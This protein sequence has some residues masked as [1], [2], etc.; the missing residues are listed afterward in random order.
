[1]SSKIRQINQKKILK[2]NHSSNTI[3]SSTKK[4]IEN[5]F[6]YH[7]IHQAS[8]SFQISLDENNKL[9]IKTKNQSKS[10]NKIPNNESS[11]L[12]NIQLIDSDNVKLR[13]VLTE[14][15]KEL[16]E[17]DLVLNQSQKLLKKINFEYTQILN[18]YQAI[19]QEKNILKK[20]NERLKHLC[21]ILN[22]NLISKEKKEKQNEQIKFELNKTK[23]LLNNFKDHYINISGDFTKI[24]K[25]MIYKDL[26]INDLKKE[27]NKIINMVHD[28]EMIIKQYSKKLSELKELIEQ[29]DEQIKLMVNFSKELNSENKLNIKEITKQAVK[30]INTFYNTRNNKSKDINSNLIEIK[31]DSILNLNNDENNGI[32][33][34]ILSKKNCCFL[35]YKAIKSDLYIPENGINFI[36]KEFLE[37]NNIKT[38]LIKTELYS[39]ILR[40]FNLFHFI[41]NR[42]HKFEE[43]LINI[44]I[45]KINYGKSFKLFK[46]IYNVIY[47]NLIKTKKENSNLKSKLNELILYIKKLKNDFSTKNKKIKQKFETLINQYLSKFNKEEIISNLYSNNNNENIDKNNKKEISELNK[48]IDKVKNINKNL[49]EEISNKD[50]IINKLRNDNNKLINKLNLYRTNPN[51]ENNFK[52]YNSF[53]TKENSTSPKNLFL[54]SKNGEDSYKN[55]NNGGG[56]LKLNTKKVLNLYSIFDN[57][58]NK[59]NSSKYSN[60]KKKENKN[61]K[62]IRKNKSD[63]NIF[64]SENNHSLKIYNKNSFIN[65]KIQ[66][67]ENIFFKSNNSLTL[68]NN[69]CLNNSNFIN[70]ILSII[71]DFTS[72]ISEE[73]FKEIVHTFF[74][75]NQIIFMLNDKISDIKNNLSLIIEK[76]KSNNK[77]KKIKPGQFMDMLHEVE[78][79]L[80]YLF[81]QL[82]KYS[83][84][85]KNILPFLKCIFALVSIISYNNPLNVNEISK[86][87]NLKDGIPFSFEI[88]NLMNTSTSNYNNK[89]NS[90]QYIKDRVLSNYINNQKSIEIGNKYF[91]NLFY[92]NTK[93]FSS[94]ELIKYRS[95]YEGLELDQILPVFKEIC[96]NFKK[97]ILNS[98]FSYESEISDIE[99]NIDLNPNKENII[100]K[101]NNTYHIVNEKIFGLKK[102]EFNFKLFFEVLKN[103]LVAF[104]IVVKYIEINM[105][106]IQYKK[107]LKRIINNLY[108][109]FEDSACLNM[110]CLDDNTIFCRKILL[111]LLLN[112]KEY[113]SNFI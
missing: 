102:F 9:N 10:S 89:F 16:K 24:E 8:K 13:E 55:N 94:S 88:D 108:E 104:E 81:N 66:Y 43:S 82:N 40:E 19:E 105:T 7:T 6:K 103:Y 110:H 83:I 84:D 93:I 101:E 33:N 32:I 48:E 77:D 29:K 51:A 87:N 85:S 37:E 99:E 64:D 72:E 25:D 60:Y 53:S 107:E 20:D 22:K 79:L 57:N 21:N 112:Q 91:N 67:Q 62:I 27:G 92:I 95:I 26:I 36:N 15:N 59:I 2:R 23:H 4:T 42:Y 46:N 70:N 39:S 52:F 111:T 113:L 58:K 35:I 96:S 68:N 73:H 90:K 54:F 12:K 44:K 38:N 86:N 47:N 28:R 31:N 34:D 78:K 11:L 100:V 18:K 69:I 3:L 63:I 14:L 50:E 1:M 76:F 106:N 61:N 41:N 80:Y 49:N 97:I 5:N 74:N 98:K 17:K 65:L 109:I 45:P 56:D 71:K 75:S 30:T